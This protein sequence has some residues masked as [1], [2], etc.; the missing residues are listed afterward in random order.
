MDRSKDEHKFT[1]NIWVDLSDDLRL[2]IWFEIWK[3][4]TNGGKDFLFEVRAKKRRHYDKKY[5]KEEGD[6]IFDGFEE[7]EM[8]IK[9]KSRVNV[10]DRKW[11]AEMMDPEEVKTLHLSKFKSHA[12]AHAYI[13]DRL[14]A[15]CNKK[16]KTRIQLAKGKDLDKNIREISSFINKY[17]EE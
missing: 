3:I 10:N 4:P 8:V 1:S 5:I 17:S 7:V 15:W 9:G 6:P 11:W 16:G 12:R 13:K 14:G 2:T